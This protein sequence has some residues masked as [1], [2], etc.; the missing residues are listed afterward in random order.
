[1][2]TYRADPETAAAVSTLL[3]GD[4]EGSGHF[5]LSTATNE[6]K[7]TGLHLLFAVANAEPAENAVFILYF[8]ANLGDAKMR[9]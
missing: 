7:G 8:E 2:F 9:R 4:F 6:A 5:T 1:M 3:G